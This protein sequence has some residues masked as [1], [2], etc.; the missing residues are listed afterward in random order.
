MAIVPGI[1][2]EENRY[3]VERDGN[4]KSQRVKRGGKNQA[5]SRKEIPMMEP[6]ISTIEAGILIAVAVGIDIGLFALEWVTVGLGPMI[7]DPVIWIFLWF[8][9]Y[10]KG[11]NFKST[12]N[13]LAL[14]IAP[15]IEAIPGLSGF[16]WVAEVVT[17][18]LVTRA[19]DELKKKGV[20]AISPTKKGRG[21]SP[22]PSA[23]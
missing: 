2:P 19:E 8:I 6:R 13:I 18:V 16:G 10:I 21:G 4:G 22:I 11:V 15:L 23:S 7:L 5:D 1:Q 9:F 12:K 3:R 14:G 17:I 20:P